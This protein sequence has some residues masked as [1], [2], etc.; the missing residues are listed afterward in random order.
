MDKDGEDGENILEGWS[1][2]SVASFMKTTEYDKIRFYTIVFYI[3]YGRKRPFTM[4]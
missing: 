3:V 1:V 4:S 2:L